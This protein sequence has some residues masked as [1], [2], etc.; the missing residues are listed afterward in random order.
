[1]ITKKSVDSDAR[2]EFKAEFE[3]NV[4]ANQ[5]EWQLSKALMACI[6]LGVLM[7]AGII[8]GADYLYRHAH[9]STLVA[10]MF[11]KITR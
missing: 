5:Q 3:R 2:A 8:W 7:W 10:S 9:A 6:P 1:M 4:V 11:E